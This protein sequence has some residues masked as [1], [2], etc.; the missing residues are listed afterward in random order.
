M[1]GGSK[2]KTPKAPPP[3]PE[4]PQLPDAG[5]IRVSDDSKRRRRAS[6]SNTILTSAQGATDQAATGQKT[7][8]GG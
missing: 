2:P 4:A 3:L 5:S 7:L 8:L 1:C 6:A